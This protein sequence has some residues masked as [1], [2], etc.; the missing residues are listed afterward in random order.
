MVFQKGMQYPSY[1]S[2][3]S[4]R[5]NFGRDE[6]SAYTWAWDKSH[7]LGRFGR[8]MIRSKRSSYKTPKTRYITQA[9]ASSISLSCSSY[10]LSPISDLS[11][12]RK[13]GSIEAVALR[14]AAWLPT[15]S[16][17]PFS[18]TKST[19]EAAFR[20][21]VDQSISTQGSYWTSGDANE[22]K[23]YDNSSNSD[24]ESFDEDNSYEMTPR[25]Y[26][27]TAAEI[28]PAL[29]DGVQENESEV[30]DESRAL[31]G[32]AGEPRNKPDSK[33]DGNA[34]LVSCISNL[35]N[36]IIGSGAY[37]RFLSSECRSGVF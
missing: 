15:F 19:T 8:G 4:S 21:P 31:L 26:G 25:S 7:V 13:D 6:D 9:A 5:L 33:K 28:M 3:L 23:E 12:E 32:R 16:L 20:K 1:R 11:S 37:P 27:T 17:N 34:T 35:L 2:H 30:L 18:P 29:P 14:L 10:K 24:H 36:T 22:A